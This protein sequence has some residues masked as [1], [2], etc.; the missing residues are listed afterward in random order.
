MC[1]SFDPLSAVL[2][3]RGRSVALTPE[4]RLQG[5]EASLRVIGV[6]REV[7]IQFPDVGQREVWEQQMRAASSSSGLYTSTI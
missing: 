1:L 4:V 2:L 6:G 3:W 7:T 5:E